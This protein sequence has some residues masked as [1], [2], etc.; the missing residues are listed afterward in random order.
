MGQ[1]QDQ[2]NTVVIGILTIMA[3]INEKAFSKLDHAIRNASSLQEV[4]A[5]LDQVAAERETQLLANRDRGEELLADIEDQ[6]FADED[7]N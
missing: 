7:E 2:T 3:S 4:R 6:F 1:R 5:M